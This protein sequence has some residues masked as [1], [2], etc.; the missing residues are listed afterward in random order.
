VSDDKSEQRACD[1]PVWLFHK[2]EQLRNVCDSE[3]ELV[4]LAR[5][6]VEEALACRANRAKGRYGARPLTNGEWRRIG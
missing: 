3:W 5:L 1:A 4:L 2:V 6:C